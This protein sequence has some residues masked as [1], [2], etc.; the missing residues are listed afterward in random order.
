MFGQ[1]RVVIVIALLAIGKNSRVDGQAAVV[2]AA[3]LANPEAFANA[4]KTTVEAMGG[5]I[6]NVDKAIG[7][8][9][10]ARGL[11]TNT[12]SGH[13]YIINLSEKEYTWYVYNDASPFKFTTQF[14]SYMGAYTTVDVH[15]LGWGAMAVFKDNKAP[16][17]TVQRDN[18]YLFDG[19]NLSHF[20]SSNMAK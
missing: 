11:I 18:V 16:Q 19:K 2:T 7:A 14:T 4:A 13:A 20:F 6:D 1:K 12:V 8:I 17:Y 10:R 9:E 3:I 5:M 15:T